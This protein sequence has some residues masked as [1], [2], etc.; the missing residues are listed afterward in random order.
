MELTE[1]FNKFINMYAENQIPNWI[2]ILGTFVPIILSIVVIRQNHIIAERNEKLQKDISS[3][4]EK[5]QESLAQKNEE[6]QKNI[7][8]NEIKIK[9]YDII[10]NV[11]VAFID[12]VSSLITT[13]KGINVILEKKE[14]NKERIKEAILRMIKAREKII[15]ESGKLQLLLKNDVDLIKRILELETIY[16]E[17]VEELSQN[18]ICNKEINSSKVLE[19]VQNYCKLLEYDNYGKYFEKYL[20]LEEMK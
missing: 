5:L 12:A 6:L 8:N 13:E 10:L 11:Y 9:K 18:F 1:I 2:T 15:L 16:K 3:N 4:N 7:L 20:S 19:K 17:I 14:E